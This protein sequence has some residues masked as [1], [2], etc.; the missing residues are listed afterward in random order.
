MAENVTQS[1]EIT[2]NDIKFQTNVG[3]SGKRGSLSYCDLGHAGGRVEQY[4]HSK[5]SGHL[6]GAQNRND[7]SN[8]VASA[9]QLAM[10]VTTTSN[11]AIP[12]IK[13]NNFLASSIHRVFDHCKVITLIQK[14]SN[15]NCAFRKHF[16]ILFN[17]A[18]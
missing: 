6:S 11:S 8:R 7:N 14:Y 5:S 3:F 15:F 1:S 13:N 16:L 2:D 18:W 17:F 12:Q 9:N 10:P 4:A